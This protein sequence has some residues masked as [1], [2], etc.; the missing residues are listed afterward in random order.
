MLYTSEDELA[1]WCRS[2]CLCVCVYVC[3][4]VLLF[5]CASCRVLITRCWYGNLS[6]V[7]S[8]AGR[9]AGVAGPASPQPPLPWPR[10]ARL[11]V[12]SPWRRPA[13]TFHLCSVCLSVSVS[14]SECLPLC[15]CVPVVAAIDL[16]PYCCCGCSCSTPP[17]LGW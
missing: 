6:V 8:S 3:V 17:L 15:V 16:V 13:V 7:S 1:F 11:G 5:I 2:P 12:L 10:T 14:C 4:C 9:A